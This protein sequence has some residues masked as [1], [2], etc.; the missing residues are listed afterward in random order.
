MAYGYLRCVLP[1]TGCLR[2][3]L[4]LVDRRDFPLNTLIVT[5]AFGLFL[6]LKGIYRVCIGLEGLLHYCFALLHTP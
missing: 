4:V 3:P 1:S 6:K 2:E 5:P